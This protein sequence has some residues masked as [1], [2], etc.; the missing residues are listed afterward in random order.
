MLT[1]FNTINSPSER[2]ERFAGISTAVVLGEYVTIEA[3][4]KGF[5]GR[6]VPEK[7]SEIPDFI[8]SDIIKNL[9]KK[10]EI[11]EDILRADGVTN[12]AISGHT[13][14]KRY[15]PWQLFDK[16]RGGI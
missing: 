4:G 11:E 8:W 15:M 16:S 1:L 12:F 2:Y 9:L 7:Y 10:L 6:E 3:V 5:D 13:E 14:Q